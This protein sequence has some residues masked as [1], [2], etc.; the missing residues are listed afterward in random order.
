MDSVVNYCC[1]REK[2]RKRMSEKLLWLKIFIKILLKSKTM[3]GE[4]KVLRQT[5]KG[6]R[7]YCDKQ[8]LYRKGGS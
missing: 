6:R 5:L 8:F 7:A 4:A 3:H 2:K 1:Q